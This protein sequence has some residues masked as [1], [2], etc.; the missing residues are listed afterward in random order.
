MSATGDGGLRTDGR[1]A[2]GR[3]KVVFEHVY[4]SFEQRDQQLE[5]L[6]VAEESERELLWSW[7]GDASEATP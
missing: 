5:V 1:E 4:K 7:V 6:K 2:T 3:P